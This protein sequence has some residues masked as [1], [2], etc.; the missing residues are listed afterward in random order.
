MPI[1]MPLAA[2]VEPPA[3]VRSVQDLAP[4]LGASA[5]Q[6]A[7]ASELSG[8]AQVRVSVE[9]GG[10]GRI[11]LA[12]ERE[13]IG[14]ISGALS[15]PDPAARAALEAALPELRS[16]LEEK[17]LKLGQLQAA[18][19]PPAGAQASGGG[20]GRPR[21]HRGALMIDDERGVAPAA[22]PAPRRA[23]ARVGRTSDWIG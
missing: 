10:M 13:A 2:P 20:D 16:V 22:A 5:D 18:P 6:M 15:A 21:D 14:T 23:A 12:L 3:P 19:P 11:D 7:V 9:V 4:M 1:L 17:G 8:R